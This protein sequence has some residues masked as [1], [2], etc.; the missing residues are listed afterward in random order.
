ML[1]RIIHSS[2]VVV[3][4]PAYLERMWEIQRAENKGLPGHADLGYVVPIISM[5]PEEQKYARC[6]YCE[7]CTLV[8]ISADDVIPRD[9]VPDVA[10]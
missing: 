10:R 9:Q 5:S 2:G 4:E 3:C 6:N 1:D 8:V 7:R